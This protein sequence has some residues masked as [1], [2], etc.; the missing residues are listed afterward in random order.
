MKVKMNEMIKWF[1]G[2]TNRHIALVGKYCRI[3]NLYYGY[4]GLLQRLTKH[5]LSK[6]YEPERTPYIY[7]SWMYKEK[8]EGRRYTIPKEINDLGA[9][10]H[11]IVNNSHHPEYHQDK[12]INLLNRKDRDG[13]PSKIIDATKMPLID[14][15]EMICDWAAMSE[16][17]GINTVREWANLVVNKRWQFNN[18]QVSEIYNIIELFEQQENQNENSK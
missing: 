18:I 11:H 3:V 5:D 15:A 17:K 12:K 2:R 13:I 16:E 9:T 1:E 7:I 10:H 4:S 6:L 14:I 8:A